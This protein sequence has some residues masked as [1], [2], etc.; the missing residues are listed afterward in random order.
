MSLTDTKV[1]NA[2]PGIKPIKMFDGGGLFLLITPQGGK[3]WRFKY[4]FDGKEKLISFGTYPEIS[5]VDARNM[6]EK[7]RSLVAKKVDPSVVRKEERQERAAA[8]E[9]TFENV[10][11]EWHT[12][13]S[14]KWVASHGDQ[15]LRRLEVNIFPIIGSMP[16]SDIKPLDMLGALQK[17]EARDAIETARRI[18]QSCGQVFRY[19]VATGR[20][21]RD[22]TADLRD[23]LSPVVRT[24]H[25]A[26]TDPDEVAGLLRAIDDYKGYKVVKCALQIAPLVFVRPGE[27]R[28]AEWSEVDFDKAEWNIP[29]ERMKMKQAHL[30][31]LHLRLSVSLKCC[32]I[33]LNREHIFSQALGLLLNR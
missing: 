29:P 3:G 14:K 5:L 19:A 33:S 1:R 2:K 6:R 28:K 9:N 18:K 13:N 26:I 8:V 32:T 15:V 4:R 17:V 16:I 20:A 25:A 10:A 22:I 27:L 23:A 11:R 31:P 12:K 24:H 7:A 21:E 30:V